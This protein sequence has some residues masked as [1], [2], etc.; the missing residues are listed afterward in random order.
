MVGWLNGWMADKK[1]LQLNDV[2][3]YTIAFYLSNYVWE[4]VLGWGHFA[5]DIISKQNV[6]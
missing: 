2:G 5:K 1:Y 6:L 4:I 3:A